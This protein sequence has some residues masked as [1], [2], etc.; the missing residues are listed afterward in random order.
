[1]PVN[2]FERGLRHLGAGYFWG[3]PTPVW[4]L[5][6]LAVVMTIV[7]A[8]TKF[9]WHVYAI[10]WNEEAA[11]LS[12]V[13]VDQLKFISFTIAGLLAALGGVLLTA[14]LGSG[15]VSIGSGYELDVIGSAWAGGRVSDRHAA[16]RR[17]G[18]RGSAQ[19]IASHQKPLKE[20]CVEVSRRHLMC[21]R[22]G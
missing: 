20:A 11:R 14:H 22:Y 1:M 13:Q 5:L 4:I 16:R 2:G 9:G 12:G 8:R 19:P 15:E 10:G 7:M 21:D 17:H 3:L 6:A 18:H